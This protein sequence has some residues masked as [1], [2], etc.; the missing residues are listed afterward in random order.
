MRAGSAVDSVHIDTLIA[1]RQAAK[2][3]R[4][5]ARADAIRA[6]LLAQGIVLKD[7]AHGTTWEATT[8]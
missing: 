5:F 6:E 7:S 8:V 1:Q 2:A 3:A 4:D